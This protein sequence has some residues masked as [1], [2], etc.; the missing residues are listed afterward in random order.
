[1]RIEQAGNRY[2]CICT[3]EERGVP[4][5]AG[6]R[7]DPGQRCW[8]TPDADKAARLANPEMA[9]QLMREQED[10]LKARATLVEDSRQ[11]DADVVLPCRD[12]LAYLPYQ[13]AGIASALKRR[14]VLFGDEMGLGKTI[15]AV[16]L[17]NADVT[18]TKIL[19]VCPATLKRNWY[20]ELSKWLTRDLRIGFGESKWFHPEATD[21]TIVNYDILAKYQDRIR[22]IEWDLLICD[23]AHLLK[24]PKT[25]R[26]RSICGIDD[27]TA[28]KEECDVLPPVKAR[29]AIFL[30]G[31]PIP[32]RPI[33]GFPLFHFLAPD[34]F[35]SFF[36]FA[37][38]YCGA[39]SN[40]FGFDPSGASNLPELQDKLRSTIMIRRLKADV[41]KEL[42][43]KRRAI[44]E[45]PAINGA[46]A[47]VAA[48]ADAFEAHEERLASLRVAVEL[49]KASDDPADYD[50]AVGAL[51]AGASVAFTEISRLRHDTAVAKIPYVVEHL[52]DIVEAGSK[53]VVF[54]HHKDVL[55][56]VAKEF[57]D[58]AVLLYGDTAMDARQAAVDRFQRH[59]E[60]LVFVG[61]ILAAGV[62]ITLTAASHVV[63]AELDWVP[64]NVTQAEDRCHRI[65]QHDCVLV[66]HLV[67]EGS[68]DARMA[69]VLV[70]KQEIQ[71]AALDTVTEAQEP[72]VP[73]KERAATESASRKQIET[74][75]AQMTP[76]RIAAVQDGL[77]QLAAMDGDRA[78]DVNGMGFSKIDVEI[79]HKLASLY[80]LTPK[81]AALGS[82]LVKK[83]R[84]QVPEAAAALD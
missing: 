69:T 43:A 28:R 18:L 26:T 74:E 50:A 15:Q 1:M 38:R 82:K 23:E 10:K 39:D 33:E 72:A 61:G 21:I 49:A 81:Q 22:A 8:W 58:K 6:F 17:I 76:A 79:G 7:W 30:T 9:A 4:K 47:A 32:N 66:Q 64:G 60:C 53:V 19:V 12:G 13:R 80:V 20:N 54:A 78:R 3:F 11:A 41:L 52:R 68:L 34:E 35:R 51:K 40:G 62:G 84:R 48:E 77:R 2:I 83:Y 75:A 59:P 31:T 16:G 71:A 57:G 67:L 14:N 29:R 27:Y 24:N 55:L 45:I 5:A 44:I 56:A 65:G 70:A 37:K 46:S 73:S 25:K 42:P 63:F 36:G